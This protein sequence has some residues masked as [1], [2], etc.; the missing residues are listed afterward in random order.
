M[1]FDLFFVEMVTST[2]ALC[3]LSAKLHQNLVGEDHAKAGLENS[4]CVLCGF[5]I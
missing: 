3:V 2:H 5:P 1:A 4:K